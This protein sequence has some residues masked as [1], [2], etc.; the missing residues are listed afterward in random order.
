MPLTT[1]DERTALLVVD[2]QNGAL[3]RPAAPH[4]AHDVIARAAEL[5]RAF[6]GHG[7]PVVLTRFTAAP[8]GSDATPGRTDEHTLQRVFP[9]LGETGTTAEI[10]VLLARTRT[11]P[12]AE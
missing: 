11:S 12:V 3:A 1:L 7:L 10:I 2:L 9:L 8:D 5:A 4:T 6:R